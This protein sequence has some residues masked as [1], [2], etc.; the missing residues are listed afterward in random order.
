M[1]QKLA[2]KELTEAGYKALFNR[3]VSSLPKVWLYTLY[4][5][6]LD[7]YWRDSKNFDKEEFLEVD[8]CKGISD[9]QPCCNSTAKPDKDKPEAE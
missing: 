1:N 4:N 3:F 5:G 2:D 9:L 6:E 7:K 8:K